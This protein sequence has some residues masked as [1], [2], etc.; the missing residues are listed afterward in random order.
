M[1]QV[2]SGDGKTPKSGPSRPSVVSIKA[3]RV[4]MDRIRW[5]GLCAVYVAGRSMEP[6][7]SACI[8]TAILGSDYW[9]LNL[10]LE[11]ILQRCEGIEFDQLLEHDLAG[12]P[13]NGLD[14]AGQDCPPSTAKI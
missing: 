2:R 12:K 10:R 7:R 11:G 6:S 8:S 13:D 4:G 5:I 14:E 9:R 1:H 3:A